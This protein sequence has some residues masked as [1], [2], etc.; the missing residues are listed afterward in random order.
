MNFFFSSRR[1][2]TRCLSD[3]SSDVCSSDLLHGC[4]H[5]A[6]ARAA[7]PTAQAAARSSHLGAD[8]V[9]HPPGPLEGPRSAAAVGGGAP[10]APAGGAARER[11]GGGVGQA[12][13]PTGSPDGG[14]AILAAR[15]DAGE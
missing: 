12:R 14:A 10:A 8:G 2:H 11:R 7:G 4:A 13:P 6:G 1:R 15:E 9:P 5:P 3:W